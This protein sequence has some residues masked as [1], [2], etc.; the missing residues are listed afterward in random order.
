MNSTVV[1][2]RFWLLVVLI[3]CLAI[4]SSALAVRWTANPFLRN[5]QNET[6]ADQ[7]L[8]DA[9]NLEAVLLQ[10][11]LLLTF[12]ASS[13]DAINVVMGYVENSDIV[14]EELKNLPRPDSLE[15]MGLFDAFGEEMAGL[16]R[17]SEGR[18][19][20]TERE[21][22]G[23]VLGI[24]DGVEGAERTVIA[25]SEGSKKHI[26]LAVPVLT[27]GL[28]EGVVVGVFTFDLPDLFPANDVARATN[29]IAYPPEEAVSPAAKSSYVVVPLDAFQL[30]V[31]LRP[32]FDAV[33]AAGRGLL[34]NSVSAVAAVLAIA[35]GIFAIV[36]RRALV[37]PHRKLEAQQESLSEL[38]AVAE[39]AND[40]I[41]VTDLQERIVW[42]NPAFLALSG[43]DKD[44]IACRR[45]GDFLQGSGTDPETRKKISEAIS[46]MKPIKTEILNYNKSGEEYWISISITPLENQ[47][48]EHYGFV[49]IS[50][51]ITE[52][53]KQT[54]SIIAAKQEV[55]YNALHDALTDLPNR[56]A[57]DETL[58]ARS[59]ADNFEA[60]LVRID[61]DHFKYVND[62]LGHQAGD[63]VLCEV[64]RILK[65]ETGPG[66]LPVRIGGDE[67]LILLGRGTDT[68]K[69][70]KLADRILQ[71]IR[72]PKLFRGKT[73]RV[74]ASFGVASTRD[75]LLQFEEVIVG[76]DA[77][78]YEAKDLGRSKVRHYT[79][80]LHRSVLD[81]RELAGSMRLAI[82]NGEFEPFFQPQFDAATYD[83]VGV[84]TLVRWRRADGKL[85]F[86]NTFMPVAKQLSCVDDIDA[87][88]FRKAI[89]EIQKLSD[90]GFDIP[91]VNFNVTAE[92]IQDRSFIQSIPD[93]KSLNVR[94]AIE[95][96]E[97]VLV[98]EQSG[99]FDFC[100]D[101]IREKGVSIEI[102]DF[103]SGHASVVGLMHLQPDVMKIDQQLV[104]PVTESETA[105]KLLEQIVGMA[106]FMGLKVTAEGVETFEHARLLEEMGC[107]TL[108]G[109]AFSKPLPV[110]ELRDFMMAHDEARRRSLLRKAQ[111]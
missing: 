70:R 102:D 111:T 16:E 46:Q 72:E 35:F 54:E 55:E 98:E 15:W 1:N 68:R 63:F 96:L 21:I 84:E 77:A 88:V 6:I 95:I 61:L 56:R 87:V 93:A 97:S 40:A 3:F 65:E 80:S 106:D 66:D 28:V 62:T 82:E 39:M 64:A 51:D 105:K 27:Y 57:L 74:S 78:L 29:I 94:I 43:Y 44:E 34:A 45:P 32:D 22:Q 18:T 36:G 103:G 91:K 67:F 30:A 50:S 10:H 90:Q 2:R 60:T 101:S 73:I 71:L 4:T 9:G 49:A 104:K 110:P 20:F 8:K 33:A 41:L 86:P 53:R 31:E 13:S 14:T 26:A 17:S 108:Q 99:F 25:K 76:A 24:A 109:F 12:F 5:H 37:E 85:I 11:Q 42:A 81:R 38:A 59:D 58:K 48:N 89:A 92:R 19:L 107:H 100:L 47:N 52:A 23:L 69:A 79:R 7:A 83:V 75:G